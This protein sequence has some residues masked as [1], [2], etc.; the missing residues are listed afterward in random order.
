MLPVL[1]AAGCWAR[2]Y[3]DPALDRL[4]TGFVYQR[5]GDYC[6]TT[7]YLLKDDKLISLSSYTARVNGHESKYEHSY[8]DEN[9]PK[10]FLSSCIPLSKLDYGFTNA[11]TKKE[12]QVNFYFNL[13]ENKESNYRPSAF[14]FVVYICKK[15]SAL[16]MREE[17][18]KCK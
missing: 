1:I 3:R 5:D 9:P 2:E 17:N 15:K 7:E 4:D 12:G 13:S 11:L 10:P 18:E 14:N 16:I 8:F 6:F